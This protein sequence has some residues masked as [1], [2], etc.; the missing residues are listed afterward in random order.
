MNE[1]THQS[2]AYALHI[3]SEFI[4]N[5]CGNESKHVEQLLTD[6]FHFQLICSVL[7]ISIFHIPIFPIGACDEIMKWW[8]THRFKLQFF[9]SLFGCWRSVMLSG[10][11]YD[12]LHPPVH[13][14]TWLILIVPLFHYKWLP[15]HIDKRILIVYA[16]LM[17]ENMIILWCRFNML[18]WQ[19]SIK[20][21]WNTTICSSSH[22]LPLFACI[23]LC[24]EHESH[25][26]FHCHTNVRVP[27]H[28]FKPITRRNDH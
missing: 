9:D 15:L 21:T 13:K 17:C 7:A 27:I 4:Q 16:F 3:S 26:S 28:K 25:V 14:I 24:S 23:C 10:R 6:S 1:H 20:W 5:D 19:K 12:P 22:I 8:T 2:N 11:P 18:L